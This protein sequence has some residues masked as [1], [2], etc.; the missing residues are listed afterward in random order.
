VIPPLALPTL[1]LAMSQSSSKDLVKS[2]AEKD[3]LGNQWAAW[4]LTD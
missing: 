3:S 4:V 1:A 2:C